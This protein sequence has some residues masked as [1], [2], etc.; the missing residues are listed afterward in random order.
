MNDSMVY[1]SSADVIKAEYRNAFMV[2]VNLQSSRRKRSLPDVLAAE[3]YELSLSNDGIHFGESINIIIYDE[4]CS[5]CNATS[6]I[7][8]VLVNILIWIIML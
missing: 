6:M 5:S 8:V 3:G 7:C 2:S 4:E 1:T